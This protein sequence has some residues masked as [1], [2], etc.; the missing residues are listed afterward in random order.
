MAAFSQGE[1]CGSV[2]F[3][4]AFHLYRDGNHEEQGVEDAERD[5]P[6]SCDGVE[7]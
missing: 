4:S 5:A 1:V 7:F 6:L 2:K 3:L